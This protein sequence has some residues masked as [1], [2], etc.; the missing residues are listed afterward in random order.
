MFGKKILVFF[1]F[2][3][4]AA[5]FGFFIYFFY[6]DSDPLQYFRSNLWSLFFFASLYGVGDSVW[7]TFPS[8]M[9]SSFFTT[10]T[11]EA[12]SNLKLWQSLG[13]VLAFFW[14]PILSFFNKLLIAA[15]CLVFGTI[16]I[17]ILNFWILN[18]DKRTSII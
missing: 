1:G 11:E 14:G 13:F 15:S 6:A 2:V 12:F 18:I 7:N 3:T 10:Q 8:V 4:H 17:L 5:F 16:C 9:C